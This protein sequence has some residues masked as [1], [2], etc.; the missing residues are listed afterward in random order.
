MNEMVYNELN[1]MKM[2][3]ENI[4]DNNMEVYSI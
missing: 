4:I 1:Q 2:M 3:R